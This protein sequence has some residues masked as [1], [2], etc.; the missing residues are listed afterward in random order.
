LCSELARAWECDEPDDGSSCTSCT[1]DLALILRG[2]GG[3][4]ARAGVL[5]QRLVARSG[6]EVE[7][8][9]LALELPTKTGARWVLVAELAESGI[10]GLANITRDG[11]LVHMETLTLPGVPGDALWV[12]AEQRDE[13][14]DAG[15]A[16]EILS[17]TRTLTLC[18]P[19]FPGG[20][21]CATIVREWFSQESIDGHLCAPELQ[22]LDVDVERATGR[23]TVKSAPYAAPLPTE[24]P[25]HPWLGEHPLAALLADERVARNVP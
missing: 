23:V 3:A 8:R 21:R 2:P 13:D 9:R 10:P 25:L 14:I 17:R 7:D 19:F 18:A 16:A 20:A 12:E 24:H 6:A 15:R 1:L 5:T 22:A 4:E 11:E